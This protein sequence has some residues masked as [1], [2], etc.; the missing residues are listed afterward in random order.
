MNEIRV[1]LIVVGVVQG[2]GFRWAARDAAGECDV[3]GWVRNLPNGS[4]EIVAQGSPDAVSCMI[5]WAERGPRHALVDRVVVE[6][7]A[8]EPGLTGFEIRR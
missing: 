3:A 8:A 6:R 5:S 7:E 1:R 4:V 2:V